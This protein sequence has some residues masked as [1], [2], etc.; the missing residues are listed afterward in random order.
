MGLNS[1][2]DYVLLYIFYICSA[3]LARGAVVFLTM[4]NVCAT[5][6]VYVFI[7]IVHRGQTLHVLAQIKVKVSS[8]FVVIPKRLSLNTK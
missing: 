8:L 3:K 1:T 7:V 4:V 6:A 2:F 5:N